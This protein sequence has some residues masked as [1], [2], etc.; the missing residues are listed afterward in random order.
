MPFD[1]YREE[2][3]KPQIR[4]RLDQLRKQYGQQKIVNADPEKMKLLVA[5]LK[6]EDNETRI[7]S[8][9]ALGDLGEK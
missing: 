3:V 1:K 5:R 2:V 4:R 7:K 9:L 8:A 6:D